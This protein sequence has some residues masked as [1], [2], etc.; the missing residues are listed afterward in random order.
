[1]LLSNANLSNNIY[2]LLMAD[3]FPNI[4]CTPGGDPNQD[5]VNA[6]NSLYQETN[7]TIYTIGLAK[8]NNIPDIN[9]TLLINIAKASPNGSYFY[10]NLTDLKKVYDNITQIIINSSVGFKLENK[11][12]INTEEESNF[13]YVLVVL[14][15]A[16]QSY[17]YKILYEDLPRS[18]LQKTYNI[19]T[20]GKI[21]NVTRVEIYP[22]ARLSSGQEYLGNMIGSYDLK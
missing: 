3:G 6:A 17:E 9:K 13:E 2:V 16:T 21:T 12:L 18:Q 8:T 7:A 22:I 20:T 19:N 14:L 10:A 15:N 11:T 5:A 1:M 4:A